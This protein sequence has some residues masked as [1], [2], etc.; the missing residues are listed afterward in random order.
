MPIR[1]CSRDSRRRID[2]LANSQWTPDYA[3]TAKETSELS[4][5]VKMG[6]PASILHRWSFMRSH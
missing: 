5:N 1:S 3:L 4:L 6:T 2:K